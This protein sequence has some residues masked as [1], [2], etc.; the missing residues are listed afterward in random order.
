[1]GCEKSS[2]SV[3]NSNHLHL[4]QNTTEP[5]VEMLYNC[6][7][8]V[9]KSEDDD[10]RT[11]SECCQV[12]G[13]KTGIYRFSDDCLDCVCSQTNCLAAPRMHEVSDF[14]DDMG[15]SFF[16]TTGDDVFFNDTENMAEANFVIDDESDDEEGSKSNL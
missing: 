16:D 13:L 7:D 6:F 4:T 10:N 9:L 8:R 12:N 5:W 14:L 3:Y 15:I 1:M 11:L 2:F